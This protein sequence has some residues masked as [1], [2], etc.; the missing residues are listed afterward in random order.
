MAIDAVGLLDALGIGKAHVI[1]ASMG[2]AI[3]QRLAISHP[4]RVLSLTSI[5]SFAEL[6]AL[7]TRGIPAN[8]LATVPT[9]EEYLGFWSILAGSTY[10]L[11][12]SLYSELYRQHV[13]V[14]KGYNPE[15]MAHHLGAIARSPFRI[16]ELPDIPVPTLVLHGTADPLVPLTH[17]QEYAGLIPKA[18][19][20]EMVGVGHDIPQG[21]CTL[22]HPEIFTL[23]QTV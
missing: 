12:I 5:A 22:I 14:R 21:I 20:I 8:L 19:F 13:E 2:G 4:N 17:A 6:T 10:P 7:E 9:L 3:A 16:A 23:L 15:G 11:D 1:G 18:R